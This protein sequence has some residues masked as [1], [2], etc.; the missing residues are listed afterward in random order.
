ML[1]P[2][3]E[4]AAGQSDQAGA[5]QDAQGTPKA[6]P[7][8]KKVGCIIPARNAAATTLLLATA[9]SVMQP[10]TSIMPAEHDAFLHVGVGDYERLDAVCSP[11]LSSSTDDLSIFTTCICIR[12]IL[13][14]LE[15]LGWL[16]RS[17][18]FRRVLL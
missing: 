7:S 6:T 15:L 1:H 3:G 10:T 12:S 11:V 5:A 16:D 14:E 17:P 4:L 8:P 18:N 13:L 2:K 9:A